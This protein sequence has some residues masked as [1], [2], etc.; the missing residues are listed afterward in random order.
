[1]PAID[2]RLHAAQCLARLARED[3]VQALRR[4]DQDV[5]RI[6]R[7]PAAR[8]GRGV[9]GAR[10]DGDLR[11]RDPLAFGGAPDAGKGSAQVA[12]HVIGERLERG[13][14]EHT[15]RSPRSARLDEET[16]DR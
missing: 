16:I 5:G 1:V 13:D 6:L 3:Q 15:H 12:L 7:E 4:R 2:H 8:L 11:Q 10:G 14:V 9:A